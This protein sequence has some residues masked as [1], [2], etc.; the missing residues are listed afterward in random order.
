VTDAPSRR[1]RHPLAAAC[2]LAALATAA[3]AQGAPLAELIPSLFDRTIVLA[4]TGHQA[5]FVDSSFELRLAGEQINTAILAQLT[6][7]PVGSSSGGFTFTFDPA[8]GVMTRSTDSFGPIFA[9]RADTIGKGKWSFALRYLAYD[10]DSIDGLDLEDGDLALSFTHLDTNN[11][12]TT[13]ATVYEGDLILADARLALSSQTT[14]VS[15]NVG[16]TETLDLSVAVPLVRVAL[17]STLE[18]HISRLATEGFEN[19]PAHQFPG[20]GESA[21]F[22][23]AGSDSGVGDILLRGKWAFARA[24]GRG[25]AALLDLRLP[26]GDEENLLGAGAT[27]IELGLAASATF[28]RFAPH[29]NIGYAVYEGDD[30][31]G[32]ELP[33]EA[34]FATGFD[35]AVHPKVTLAA[36]LLWR[37]LFDA[38][39]LQVRGVTHLYRPFDSTQIQSTER[40]VL[41]TERQDLNVTNLAVGIKVNLGGQ[42]LVTGNL[43]YTASDSGLT[44]EDIV[45]M[46]GVETSF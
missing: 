44:D 24:E 10:F 43:L 12:G 20:G 16:L 3:G 23:A 29:A 2:A 45:P 36:D 17:E 4:T 15:A 40:P 28:G 33:D 22:R 27:Q 35:W 25:L 46:I 42:V 41:E 18:T 5:H 8:L 11:D 30:G 21:E 34:A 14:I 26:T 32:G 13:V 1:A 7:Y 38:N 9:E 31:G 19:P 37:T 6:S 39:Q